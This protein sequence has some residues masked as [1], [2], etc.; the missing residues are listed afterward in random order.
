MGYSPRD[1]LNWGKDSNRFLYTVKKKGIKIYL[2]AW[3]FTNMTRPSF[4]YYTDT[5]MYFLLAQGVIC[6][7]GTLT[8]SYTPFSVC[9][10]LIL[11]KLI[12]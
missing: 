10:E 2:R 4:I 12:S 1:W 8:K 5:Y 7:N 3:S 6:R 9:H 11:I